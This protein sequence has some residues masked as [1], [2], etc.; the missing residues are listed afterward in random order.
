MPVTHKQTEKANAA[1]KGRTKKENERNSRLVLHALRL[2]RHATQ[3]SPVI[4]CRKSALG[5]RPR[6]HVAV[7]DVG[8]PFGS[9]S[10]RAGLTDTGPNTMAWRCCRCNDLACKTTHQTPSLHSTLPGDCRQSCT[11][12]PTQEICTHLTVISVNIVRAVAVSSNKHL[13]FHLAVRR[14]V[15]LVACHVGKNGVVVS[16]ELQ[17]RSLLNNGNISF[18]PIAAPRG[19]G[20]C[21]PR[22]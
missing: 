20:D 11:Q 8:F 18:P 22:P 21:T 10:D 5:I 16:L 17:N 6:G 7:A 1:G 19:A 3:R 14:S 2:A 15:H 13:R 4:A 12:P 9:S